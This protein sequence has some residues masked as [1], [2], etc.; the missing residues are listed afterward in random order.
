[1][2]NPATLLLLFFISIMLVIFVQIGIFRI[3]LD[4]LGLSADSGLLIL[5]TSLFGS[6]VN[7]PLGR[8]QADPDVEPI[9]PPRLPSWFPQP[10]PFT[11]QTIIASNV[12]VPE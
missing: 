3:A 6:M 4:K 8:M 5:F 2:R 10:I 9:T 11:G 1:M 12:W 7:L